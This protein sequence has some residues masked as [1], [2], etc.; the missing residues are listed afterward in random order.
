[1]EKA[2][3]AQ[4]S[5]EARDERKADQSQEAGRRRF[6]IVKLEERIAP[7]NPASNPCTSTQGHSTHTELRA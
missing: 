4:P 5:R 3:T 1:M 6:R 2:S 7:S